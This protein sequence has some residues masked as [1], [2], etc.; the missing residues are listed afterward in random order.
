MNKENSLLRQRIIPI[1]L[2]SNYQVVKSRQFDDY[3]TFG[4][5]E[6]TI[7]VFNTRNVDEIIILDIETSKKNKGVNLD[8]LKIISR[9]SIMP[10]TYGGG[11]TSLNDIELCLKNG[12]DKVSINTKC[13]NDISFI[14]KAAKAFGSQCIV[15]SVDYKLINNTYNIYSHSKNKINNLNIIKYI[16]DLEDCGSGELIL[17]SVN[18]EGVM[19]GYEITLLK[20]IIKKINIPIILNGGCG[21]PKDMIYPLKTGV[22]GLAV[23][24]IFYYTQYSYVDIKNYLAKKKM[25]VR[26]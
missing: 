17:T 26:I 7:S 20:K 19:K 4:N 8:V 25:N 18:H 3:R 23:S 2:F 11:I 14:S 5:L 12:C 6:H 10:L 13:I 16:T 1:I 21:E 24:S 9:N 22:S 15:S